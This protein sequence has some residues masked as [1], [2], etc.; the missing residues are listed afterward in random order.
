M[1]THHSVF[2]WISIVTALLF[3]FCFTSRGQFWDSSTGLLQAPSAEMNRDGTF[4]IT[5]NFMNKHSIS[6]WYWGYHTFEYGLNI[7]LWSRLEI[8][9]VCVLL[10]GKRKANPGDRDLIMFNQDRHFN[11]KVLL[12]R[13][14]DFGVEWLPAMAIGVSD[15]ISAAMSSDYSNPNVSGDSNGFFNRCYFVAT[16][17][18]NTSIGT[19]GTHLGYQ[20][21]QRTDFP[22]NGPCAA[23]DWVPVWLNKPNFTLKAIAEYDS[24]TFNVGFIAT[25]W[26]DRFEAMFELMALKWV[27]FGIRYKLHLKS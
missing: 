18:F 15:P 22:M 21:N 8:G 20:Y 3:L 25:I 5:N 1:E 10:D 14:G 12:V 4:M 17:H 24:R 19:L 23:I 26:Q 7:N 11:A 9:Y 6:Q 27:N 13:E 16:K 2:R